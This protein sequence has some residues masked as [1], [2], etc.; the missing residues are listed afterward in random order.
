MVQPEA[1]RF[2]HAALRSGLID[3]AK[4]QACWDAVPPE[5]RTPDAIDRRLAR[6]SILLG[7]LTLWQAQQL[8]SGRSSRF[9]IGKY[10][11]LDRIGQGGMGRVYL[12][13]DT[14]LNRQVALKVLSPDR[15][16]NP[17]AIVRFKRE[18]RVG[19][20]LQHEHLVRVY[21]EGESDGAPYLVMEYIEGKNAGQLVAEGGPMPPAL[22]ARLTRQVALGLDHA[23]RKNLIH[24]DVNPYNILVTRD[25]MAKL[26]DLGL[27][28]D[29][30]DEDAVTR[31]GAT[32]GTFDYISPEQARHSRSV[33]TRSD[34]YSLGCTLYHL[35]SGRVPFP[36]PSLPE[37][38]FAHHSQ[39]PEPLETLVPGVPPGLDAVVAR[40]MR[41]DPADRYATP[42]EV[43]EALDPFALN[44]E[45][46]PGVRGRR[47]ASASPKPSDFDSSQAPENGSGSKL[48]DSN[49]SDSLSFLKESQD[50]PPAEVMPKIDLSPEF[51][52]SKS[53]S[54]ERV[55]DASRSLIDSGRVR[56]GLASAL[57]L[58]LA[59]GL[60]FARGGCRATVPSTVANQE[61]LKAITPPR[62]PPPP[63][64]IAV[65]YADGHE[66]PFETDDPVTDLREAIRL[67]GDENAEVVLRNRDPLPL[68]I[69]TSVVGTGRLVIL[70]AA[71]DS[72]P[73]LEIK[74]AGNEP[75]LRADPGTAILLQGLEVRVT[76]GDQKGVHPP[77]IQASGGLR[78]ESCAFRT[79]VMGGSNR[80]VL[81][82]QGTANLNGCWFEGFA[83]PLTMIASAGAR[84][85]ISQCILTRPSTAGREKGWAVSMQRPNVG[86]ANKKAAT[87]AVPGDPAAKTAA[88]TAEVGPHPRLEIRRCTVAGL[89]LL[90]M[91]GFTPT[92]PLE[93]DMVES[94]IQAEALLCW[95]GRQGF[96]GPMRWTGL[97]N[98]Y[99]ILGNAWVCQSVPRTAGG[100]PQAA[101]PLKNG[102]TDLASWIKLIPNDIEAD[103]GPI[104]FAGGDQP[105]DPAGYAIQGHLE[106]MGADPERVWAPGDPT[107]GGR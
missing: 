80:V 74:L 27:A 29:L 101:E 105:R 15:L 41:K 88:R 76:Y 7:H 91:G 49:I 20:Q 46:S 59:L 10:V 67:A 56:L 73:V 42:G 11:L 71:R 21:D 5:K 17:R 44:A 39:H 47:D 40:M 2:W 34:I 93:V 13:L 57:V 12:A 18:A 86:A 100:G 36:M 48:S 107:S 38:L 54:N 8:H 103:S 52:L 102:P 23:R 31:D 60:V 66:R 98:C 4:L 72:N 19:A 30:A 55:R 16:N 65:H 37:K 63:P 99:H 69:D 50:P 62:T 1:S 24:R 78:I 89:G 53:F 75:F 22:A 26:T 96:P 25:G 77:L 33:D 84:L 35:V 3:V 28:I 14:R 85:D 81:C 68:R 51:I 79:S 70:R 90:S 6:E 61:T 104:Q 45:S 58:L 92:A 97:G 95:K 106:A 43:A 64:A 83:Q 82:N 32:V 9:R 87:K 94:A